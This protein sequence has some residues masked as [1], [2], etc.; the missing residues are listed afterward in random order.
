MFSVKRF[1]HHQRKHLN[2]EFDIT[3][4]AV[5]NITKMYYMKI[6]INIK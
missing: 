5:I 2:F 1:F 3:T 6:W 4:A